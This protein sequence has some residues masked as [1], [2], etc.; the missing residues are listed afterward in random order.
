M[1]PHPFLLQ[2]HFSYERVNKALA[3]TS[4]VA[5]PV[6]TSPRGAV[7]GVDTF[8][9]SRGSRNLSMRQ[10]FWFPLLVRERE[11]SVFV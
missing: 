11:V 6:P 3:N 10:S 2:V 7:E 5:E 8:S 1:T 9:R 4:R